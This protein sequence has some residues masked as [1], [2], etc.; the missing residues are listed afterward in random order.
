MPFINASKH[1][2]TTCV[3]FYYTTQRTAWKHRKTHA[4]TIRLCGLLHTSMMIILL[5][6]ILVISSLSP[7]M[8]RSGSAYNNL[9]GDR[10]HAKWESI[11]WHNMILWYG[12]YIITTDGYL[13]TIYHHLV[14]LI[15]GMTVT[16]IKIGCSVNMS[17]TVYRCY[18]FLWFVASK[19]ELL[20]FTKVFA[21]RRDR[22]TGIHFGWCYTTFYAWSA[23]W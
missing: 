15:K 9:V 7:N 3:I 13:N 23:W 18:L 1:F 10:L 20:L 2:K 21:R 8:L 11:I 5:Y 17:M 12:V 14:V 6:S 4:D 16:P 19:W 22:Q